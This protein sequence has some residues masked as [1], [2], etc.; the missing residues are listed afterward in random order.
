MADLTLHDE[1]TH[2]LTG[3]HIEEVRIDG[4]NHGLP[5]IIPLIGLRLIGSA[6]QRPLIGAVLTIARD[7]LDI[8]FSQIDF[9]EV[10][11]ILMISA[12]PVRNDFVLDSAVSKRRDRIAY[13]HLVV[14]NT[15]PGIRSLRCERF[16][17]P[18]SAETG[19]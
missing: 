8:V 19:R 2:G 5:R 4:G 9:G 16:M 15:R 3:G 18:R 13:Q 10:L 12:C 7:D 17:Q 11:D 6:S 14:C 1:S